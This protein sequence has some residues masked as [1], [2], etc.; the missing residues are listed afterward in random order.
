MK[1]E[2]D[3]PRPAPSPE[4]ILRAR[5]GYPAFREHQEAIIRHLVGAGMPSC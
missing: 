4:E 2:S 5:F 1:H 3:R